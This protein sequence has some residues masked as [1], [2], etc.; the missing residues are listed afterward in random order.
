MTSNKNTDTNK[1]LGVV[2]LE[3]N[4]V[5]GWQFKFVVRM[6]EKTKIA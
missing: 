4:E 3:W 2:T 5:A 6:H 1:M